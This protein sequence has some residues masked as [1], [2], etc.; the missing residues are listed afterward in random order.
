MFSVKRRGA[1]PSKSQIKEIQISN[2]DNPEKATEVL[3]A[4]NYDPPNLCQGGQGS[5]VIANTHFAHC[6]QRHSRRGCLNFD[7]G[8]GAQFNVI[9]VIRSGGSAK[10]LVHK[11]TFTNTYNIGIRTSDAHGMDI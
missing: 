6:G 4:E 7:P 9:A 8:R 3:A 1:R 11:N 2:A 10:A 5:A